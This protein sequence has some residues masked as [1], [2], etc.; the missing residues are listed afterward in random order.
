MSSATS[1][2]YAVHT[3]KGCT[4]HKLLQ[5]VAG[6]QWHMTPAALGGVLS[7]Q[8]LHPTTFLRALA[9]THAG[10]PLINLSSH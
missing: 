5:D 4:L 10:K 2:T 9:E 3:G 1:F 6:S 7:Q 8:H